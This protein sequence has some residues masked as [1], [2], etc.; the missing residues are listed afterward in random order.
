MN[1]QQ[2]AIAT[3]QHALRRLAEPLT[4]RCQGPASPATVQR[5]I[6]QAT[7]A[8]LVLAARLSKATA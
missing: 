5:F 6:D 7:G 4:Q 3:Y 8:A 2:Q 1:E